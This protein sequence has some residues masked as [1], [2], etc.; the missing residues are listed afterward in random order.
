MKEVIMK[1]VVQN[2]AKYGK[3]NEKAVMGKVMAENPE[4]RK[5][6]KEVLEM[7]RECINEFEALSEEKKR[8]LIQKY[9]AEGEAKKESETR[10]LPELEGAEKGKV[11]MRFAPN[12]NGPPTLGSARGIIVNGEYARMY[13]GKYI[14]RFDDTD[15]RTK[16]PM[17]EA[18]DWYLEDIEWLGYKPDEVIYASKRIPIYYDYARKLI[19][20]G[21]A[22]TCFCSQAEFKKFRDSGEECPHRNISVEDALEVWERMLEGDY[23]EGEVV[24]RIKTDMKHKDPAIRDWVAFR[25]IK[26]VHP[27]VGDKYVVYPTLDFE[28]AIEDHLLGVTHIIRGKDLIDSERRQRYI[29]EYFGWVYPITKH[30]GRVKIFEFGKLSTSSIKKDIERGK[31]EGWD[32]PRLP[33]LRAFRR[34]GFEPEAIK[35]FFLSLGVGE[36]DVSVSLKNL[37][38]EN[39]KIIDRKANRYFF[40]WGP[41]KIEIVNLPEKKEV[42]LPLNPHTG[43]KRRLKGERTI[44]VTKDDFE[45]LKGQ[46]VRLKDFCNVLLDEKAEF[47]GFELEGVK[48]GKNIIHWLPESEAIKGKVIGER[49]AEGLVERNAVRDVGK[50]VQFE[51]FAFC[52]VESADE[53]LVAVYTHP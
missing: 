35:S 17:L 10:G 36:N 43:E 24:L 33:T 21:K 40:I 53:E 7:V 32:D 27:L 46:V 49:E 13:E 38:A 23:E 29:Y 6:A 11:V 20:M 37:Y 44:Y 34:R 14:I 15:P 30:W 3:A 47:M 28:S 12:P 41:V 52:K 1:Y 50:V 48:K 9:S 16:R 19:E 39:R 4:L 45:R 51:R 26:E 25:I 5:K 31:Y 22:Y 8:E 18:Y 2:A 42:E